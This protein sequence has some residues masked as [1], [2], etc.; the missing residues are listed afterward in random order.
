VELV[1][2]VILALIALSAADVH[3]WPRPAKAKR[4]ARKR[5]PLRATSRRA[6]P[7]RRPAPAWGSSAL[8]RVS[9]S[10]SRANAAPLWWWE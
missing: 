3:L 5:Q 10:R 9:C 6:A 8:A 7:A 2:T 4:R 1:I